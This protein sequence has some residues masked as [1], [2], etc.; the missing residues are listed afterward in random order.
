MTEEDRQKLLAITQVLEFLPGKE[1]DEDRLQKYMFALRNVRFEDL[2]VG[3]VRALEE[4]KMQPS[5]A[6]LKELAGLGKREAERMWLLVYSKLNR[7]EGGDFGPTVNAAIRAIGGWGNLCTCPHGLMETKRK[8]FISAYMDLTAFPPTEAEGKPFYGR[9][10]GEPPR[11]Q[12][13]E[14]PNLRQLE[15]GKRQL[16]T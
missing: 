3:C 4:C 5:P 13:P 2:R 15:G 12:L 7:Y 11:H 14:A 9:N 1:V 6:E 16:G 8:E 10:G